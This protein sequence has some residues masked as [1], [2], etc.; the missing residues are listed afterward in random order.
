[1]STQISIKSITCPYLLKELTDFL[2][3]EDYLRFYRTCRYF[4]EKRFDRQW[5]QKQLAYA[6]KNRK[7]SLEGII[8]RISESSVKSLPQELMAEIIDQYWSEIK[9]NRNC[10]ISILMKRL[11]LAKYIIEPEKKLLEVEKDKLIKVIKQALK[12]HQNKLEKCAS[13]VLITIESR[14]KYFATLGDKP[15]RGRLVFYVRD[16]F[17]YSITEDEQGSIF[18][19]VLPEDRLL[20]QAELALKNYRAMNALPYLS[21]FFKEYEFSEYYHN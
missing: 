4:N 17:N 15:I 2:E 13:E 7:W 14:L 12:D 20:K 21:P 18:S 9:K 16:V 11:P 8:N 5:S 3:P 6:S 1:M 10:Y 19:S